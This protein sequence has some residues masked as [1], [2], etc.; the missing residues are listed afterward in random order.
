MI[1][2]NSQP[3]P[4]GQEKIVNF[5]ER[6]GLK[7]QKTLDKICAFFHNKTNNIFILCVAQYKNH[8]LDQALCQVK[9]S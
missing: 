7:W 9:E 5:L 4:V 3:R 1:I 8:L 2:N 6:D